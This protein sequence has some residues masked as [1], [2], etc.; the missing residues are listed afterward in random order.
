MTCD[1]SSSIE[2]RGSFARLPFI[3]NCFIS[4]RAFALV[5]AMTVLYS[6]VED[7]VSVSTV[8]A[9]MACGGLHEGKEMGVGEWKEGLVGSQNGILRSR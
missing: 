2:T 3:A 7:M 9:M 8:A 4:S 6:V 5:D 1:C